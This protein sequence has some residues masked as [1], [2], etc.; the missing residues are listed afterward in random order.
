MARKGSS[1]SPGGRATAADK[2]HRG[3]GFE[4]AARLIAR[5][6]RTAAKGRGF[7][8]ARLITHWP[9]IVGEDLARATRPIRISHAHRGMGATLLLL[10]EGAMAPIVAMQGPVIRARVNAVYGHDAIARVAL[11]QTAATGFAEPA[12]PFDHAPARPRGPD[13][14]LCR[15]AEEAASEV[16]DPGLRAALELLGRNVMARAPAGANNDGNDEEDS[17]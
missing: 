11:V 8:A 10:V 17:E 3:R 14:A 4:P 13:P 7:A 1:S 16:R 9:E 15:R 5:H 12:T 6:V 2:R